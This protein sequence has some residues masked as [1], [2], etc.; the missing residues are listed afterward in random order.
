[1]K[2]NIPS[3]ISEFFHREFSTDPSLIRKL[4]V[5]KEK[6][7]DPTD[8]LDQIIDGGISMSEIP[9]NQNFSE[10]TEETT[11]KREEIHNDLMEEAEAKFPGINNSPCRGK[12]GFVGR[13]CFKR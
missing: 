3:N 9:V 10:N 13:E 4:A 1:M 11:A 8:F 12:I 7:Y 6:S 2:Q 5:G